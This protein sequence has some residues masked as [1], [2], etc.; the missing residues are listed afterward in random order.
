MDQ[1]QINEREWGDAANWRFGV[2]RA[3]LD[4]R[5]WVPKPRK[6]MGWTLNFAHLAAYL[7]LGLL[8]LP[9]L[10]VVGI[11]MFVVR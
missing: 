9:A 5:V 1:H 7:W 2:Y 11:S 6:W 10:L 3:P 4:S 8:L